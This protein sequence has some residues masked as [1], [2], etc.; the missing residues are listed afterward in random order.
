MGVSSR[1][2]LMATITL[3]EKRISAMWNHHLCETLDRYARLLAE[4]RR[5][6][7]NTILICLFG[8]SLSIAAISAPV[9]VQAVGTQVEIVLGLPSVRGVAA[10]GTTVTA[11]LRT[12]NGAREIQGRA[13]TDT[14]GRFSI[15]MGSQGSPNES[16]VPYR[17]MEGD[18]IE[19]DAAGGDPV[20][21]TVPQL[22]AIVDLDEEIVSGM[23][24]ARAS[25]SV[26]VLKSAS[27]GE[28]T[29]VGRIDT[30][31]DADGRYF[32]D[33]A[34][35]AEPLNIETPLF[36]RVVL[37]DARRHRFI[38][39]WGPLTTTVYLGQP[40]IK[41]S[42]ASGSVIVA[43]LKDASGKLL[44]GGQ[45]IAQGDHQNSGSWT[46]ELKDALGQLLKVRTGDRLSIVAGA[47]H[48]DVELPL[49]R[50]ALLV[51]EGRISGQTEPHGNG[52][53]VL[54][55]QSG[56]PIF[57][58][59]FKADDQG[60]FSANPAD[61]GVK[62]SY[63]SYIEVHLYRDRNRIRS[64]E[65]YGAVYVNFDT[66][67]VRA[68]AARPGDLVQA[69]L[70]RN[71]AEIAS[72][73]GKALW[74]SDVSLELR[75]QNGERPVLLA[76][77]QIRVAGNLGSDIQLTL[78]E[79]ALDVRW[80]EASL[81]G[82]SGPGMD[83]IVWTYGVYL[84]PD[85]DNNQR[86]M[87]LKTDAAGA[88]SASLPY[89]LPGQEVTAQVAL[90]DGHVVSRRRAYNAA[91]IQLE[92]HQVCGVIE[93]GETV[94]I[95]I[96]DISGIAVASAQ[97]KS[98][99]KGRFSLELRDKAGDLAITKAGQ[100]IALSFGGNLTTTMTVPS[101]DVRV[102][103][104]SRQV[105]AKADQLSA[106]IAEPAGTCRSG[107][108]VK[109]RIINREA[110]GLFHTNVDS[111]LAP[112]SVSLAL[113]ESNGHRFYH[114]Y[115][116]FQVDAVLGTAELRGTGTPGDIV[117]SRYQLSAGSLVTATSTVDGSGLWSLRFPPLKETPSRLLSGGQ[118]EVSNSDA[119]QAITLP[120]FDF[121]V[122]ETNGIVGLAPPGQRLLLTISVP[123]HL[124]DQ[125]AISFE[126]MS[127]IDGRFH[128]VG[129]S[130]SRWSW[131]DVTS[132]SAALDIEPGF[133]VLRVWAKSSSP[134][135]RRRIF[136]PLSSRLR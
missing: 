101:L 88:F 17:I 96:V 58:T 23:A 86:R 31:T 63:N 68:Y 9:S 113:F 71:G 34:S 134:V 118:I 135:Q 7:Y 132:I 16:W 30:E 93:F 10:P 123:D 35:L 117:T 62:V 28:P 43:T 50:A 127:G 111:T 84:R 29:E 79:L 36:G 89:S 22:T 2:W 131:S 70:L 67:E 130:R 32:A 69:T 37:S 39:M 48:I 119:V 91:N 95:A 5:S 73:A 38:A 14:S 100:T 21:V 104:I 15:P 94:S 66:A 6:S 98:D 18:T 99:N 124:L 109:E 102:D 24:P 74:R 65:Y 125:P 120:H 80:P 56:E 1:G 51:D 78:P 106:L 60:R 27:H 45:V 129:P 85:V 107:R 108:N 82:R 41:G 75:Q 12:K 46:I 105:V 64:L 47:N 55:A 136:L 76:G 116:P 90:P 33:F 57:S 26:S 112:P 3:K 11:T 103:W 8:V 49:L 97:G 128:V 44:G 42:S 52:F 121:D 115:R 13:V 92:G 77:D 83:V 20:L 122:D 114:N 59:E 72:S 40:T 133:R 87:V 61:S 53:V 4:V 19:V 81:M 110:D 126:V 25:L 54:M